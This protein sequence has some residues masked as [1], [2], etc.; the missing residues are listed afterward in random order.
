MYVCGSCLILL[1]DGLGEPRRKMNSCRIDDTVRV[2]GGANHDATP[3]TRVPL[4]LTGHDGAL[5]YWP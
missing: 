1:T 2:D 3:G 4:C 5:A